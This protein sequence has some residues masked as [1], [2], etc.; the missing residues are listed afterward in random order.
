MGSMLVTAAN[1]EFV[2][3]SLAASEV[4]SIRTIMA[5]TCGTKGFLGELEN[6]ILESF[7]PFLLLSEIYQS[8]SQNQLGCRGISWALR[9]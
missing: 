6:K 1:V 4:E 5:L 9:E 7:D 3:E 8:L 2:A